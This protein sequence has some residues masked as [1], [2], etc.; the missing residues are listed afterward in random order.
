MT[1]TAAPCISCHKRQRAAANRLAA[2]RSHVSNPLSSLSAVQALLSW[3]GSAS[4]AHCQA[5]HE[6]HPRSPRLFVEGSRVKGE[7]SM[8]LI[9]PQRSPT[10]EIMYF[11]Q[12]LYRFFSALTICKKR[13]AFLTIRRAV[14]LHFVDFFVL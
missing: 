14:V 9:E 4:C 8:C 6:T 12:Q 1:L 3:P 7:G 13:V 10:K 11:A 5:L 2:A